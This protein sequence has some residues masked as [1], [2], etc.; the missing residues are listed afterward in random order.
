[1]YLTFERYKAMGGSMDE[2]SFG[3]AEPY[4]ETMLDLITLRRLRCPEA[5]HGDP[6]DVERAMYV[7]AD[8]AG[9]VEAAYR[10]KASGAEVSSFNNGVDSFTFA[11]DGGQGNAALR[12]LT[13]HAAQ[14]LPLELVSL[15]V[16][17]NH[18]LEA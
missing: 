15:D 7:L 13:E 16:T 10:A 11:S 14:F 4:A 3:A 18:A 9:Q 1:M 5:D 2:A 17:Y 6:A 12:A 8:G